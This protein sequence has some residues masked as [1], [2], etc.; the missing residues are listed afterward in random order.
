MTL[1][2]AARHLGLSTRTLRRWIRSGKLQ[3]DLRPGPYGQ[4]YLVPIRQLDA[5]QIVRDVERV[6]RKEEH[7]LVPRVLEEYL[8]EREN[9][10]ELALQ[11]L[12]VAVQ[13]LIDRQEVMQAEL[14]QTQRELM[15]AL[16]QLRRQVPAQEERASTEAPPLRRDAQ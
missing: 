2:Q 4:Q 6:E 7:A 10:V 5:V 15:S 16:D 1:E 13:R 8:A 14:R 11:E 12:K 9:T 3:A